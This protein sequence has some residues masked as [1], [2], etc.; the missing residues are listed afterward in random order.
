[1]SGGSSGYNAGDATKGGDGQSGEP[2]KTPGTQDPAV[3]ESVTGQT[4]I[5][6]ITIQAPGGGDGGNGGNG[7]NAGEGGFP[8][9][10]G[11]KPGFPNAANSLTVLPGSAGASGAPADGGAGGGGGSGHYG[12]GGNHVAYTV[13]H[14][15]AGTVTVEGDTNIA[16]LDG[17]DGGN[18]GNEGDAA[19][20]YYGTQP[21]GG[22]GGAGGDGGNAGAVTLIFMDAT[23]IFNGDIRVTGG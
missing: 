8:V 22:A 16:T 23:A 21:P 7:G 19:K 17:G 5:D 11:A 13:D 18:G 1:M 15:D 14:A 20:I 3:T 10:A 4:S 12:A 2:G 6:S 9:T